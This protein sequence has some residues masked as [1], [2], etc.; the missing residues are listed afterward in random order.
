VLVDWQCGD[1]CACV[2]SNVSSEGADRQCVCVLVRRAVD[3]HLVHYIRC[4]LQ[5]GAGCTGSTRRLEVYGE[6]LF[7]NRNV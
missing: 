6:L 4:S 3:T 2:V 1:V 7:D 5:D